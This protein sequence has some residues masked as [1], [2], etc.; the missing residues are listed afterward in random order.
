MTGRVL[1][2]NVSRGG[3]PK[4]PIS[5]GNLTFTGFE[6]DS[7]AHPQIHGGPDQTVLLIASEAIDAMRAKGYPVYAGALGENIT[8]EGLD[9][10]VW[11]AGQRYR[12]GE[13]MIELTKVR[14]PCTSLNV[15][16]PSIQNE[17]YDSLVKAKDP[18][19]PRWAL[20]GFYARV[21][22][23]GLVFPGNIIS[24]VSELA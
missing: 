21:V 2:I 17:I 8:T 7:W 6:G 24:L 22:T 20:S 11:R 16:G 19:S 13:A 4:R 5:E 1:Q 23:P 18:T 9:P 15:Y 3:L 14:A 10:A 12:V